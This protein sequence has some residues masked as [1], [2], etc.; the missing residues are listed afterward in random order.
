M[1]I[2]LEIWEYDRVRI[3]TARHATLPPKVSQEEGDSFITFTS[4]AICHHATKT[5]IKQYKTNPCFLT[6]SGFVC[7]CM[8]LCLHAL[9]CCDAWEDVFVLAS[10]SLC[11]ACFWSLDHTPQ[12]ISPCPCSTVNNQQGH[13]L[14][15][16]QAA[17]AIFAP[18]FQLCWDFTAV[19][20]TTAIP[21][22]NPLI[23]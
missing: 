17:P 2:L 7:V 8:S 15:L 6:R 22:S 4:S 13:T 14:P 21:H 3:G 5:Q 11:R 1:F 10:L 18:G 19:Q 23:C 9:C 16:M 20:T 12:V